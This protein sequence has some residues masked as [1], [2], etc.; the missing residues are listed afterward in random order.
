[1]AVYR[2]NVYRVFLRTKRSCRT[3]ALAGDGVDQE[4]LRPRGGKD[5][6]CVKV[7]FEQRNVEMV[8]TACGADKVPQVR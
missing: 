7:F 5:R 2:G 6:L 8:R 4:A 3:A 1:M